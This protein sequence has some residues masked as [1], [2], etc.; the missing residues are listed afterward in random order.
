MAGLNTYAYQQT[1]ADEQYV[2]GD[3]FDPIA[4]EDLEGFK[5]QF[6]PG[7]RLMVNQ[8][9]VGLAFE[10]AIGF[11]V[12]G[13][14]GENME[15]F[16]SVLATLSNDFPVIISEGL[17]DSYLRPVLYVKTVPNGDTQLGLNGLFST[18]K[19]WVQGGY[20]SFMVLRA[21]W[22]LLYQTYFQSE[23]LWNLGQ[24]TYW[25]MKTLP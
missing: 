4:L 19:F 5:L 12:S 8:F 11:N 3:E 2:Q 18:S 9:S 7:L 21:D 23:V 22:V 16:Q 6:S 20:N 15:N 1:V 17:G 24:M 13:N 10:N 25:P 14:S